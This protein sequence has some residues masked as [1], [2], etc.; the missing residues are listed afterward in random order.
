MQRELLEQQ[1]EA[2]GAEEL[3][4]A[5][6][7]YA[8]RIMAEYDISPEN[9]ASITG[10]TPGNIFGM[11]FGMIGDIYA[12]PLKTAAAV[13]AVIFLICLMEAFGGSFSGKTISGVF[14]FISTAAAGA[15]LILP[16]MD[17]VSRGI[18]AITL[19]ANFM[20][21]LC[22]IY[23]GILI[24]AGSPASAAGFQSLVFSAAQ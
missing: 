24:A 9:P 8:G 13:I 11:M 3:S 20:L 22:P 19:S 5:L 7:D 23:A 2:S 16:V 18:G 15:I 12:A 4:D 21:V 6:P 10:L 14:Q 1:Y 17:C